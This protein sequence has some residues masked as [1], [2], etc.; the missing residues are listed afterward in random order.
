MLCIVKSLTG[1][2]NVFVILPGSHEL[3]CCF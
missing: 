3:K 1:S 2:Y